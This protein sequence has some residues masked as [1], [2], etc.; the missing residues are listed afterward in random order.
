MNVYRDHQWCEIPANA[1]VSDHDAATYK[2]LEQC[3]QDDARR[4]GVWPGPLCKPGIFEQAVV[5][6]K[7]YVVDSRL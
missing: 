5:C 6:G 4:C 2:L 7:W 3:M 1:V